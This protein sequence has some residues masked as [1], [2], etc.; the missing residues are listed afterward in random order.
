MRYEIQRP[1]FFFFF[2]IFNLGWGHFGKKKKKKVR[3]VK[4]QQFGSF[5]FGGGGGVK[6][7]ILNIEGQSANV[8][9]VQGSKMYFPLF[10][11]SILAPIIIL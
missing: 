9:I 6:C 5:F 2:L 1:G 4:L 3:M 10:N 8:W 11:I 7:Y